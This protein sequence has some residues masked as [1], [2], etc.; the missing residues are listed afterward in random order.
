M[1]SLPSFPPNRHQCHAFSFPV[2]SYWDNH[3][4]LRSLDPNA[5]S[6]SAP[7]ATLLLRRKQ[8]QHHMRAHIS[9]GDKICVH[10][11]SSHNTSLLAPY[12][13][14]PS[15]QIWAFLHC[16]RLHLCPQFYLWHLP[17]IILLRFLQSWHSCKLPFHHGSLKQ[18]HLTS[19]ILLSKSVPSPHLVFFVSIPSLSSYDD[20]ACL[21][22]STL[23]PNLVPWE[24]LQLNHRQVQHPIEA[25]IALGRNLFHHALYLLHTSPI[26]CSH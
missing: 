7:W 15:S 17:V 21:Q 14:I 10:A 22:N 11:L 8:E 26:I 1:L 20:L 6:T 16:L 18:P 13:R 25:C 12:N 9:R 3:S 19:M 2:P 4:C 5:Q 24:L 23:C